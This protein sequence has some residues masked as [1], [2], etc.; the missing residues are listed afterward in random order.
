MMPLF[1]FAPQCCDAINYL[2]A[3]NQC[4]TDGLCYGD[5]RP[6]GD[7]LWFAIPHKL[8]WP[9]ESLITINFILLAI[10]SLLSARAFVRLAA[11]KLVNNQTIITDKPKL[12]SLSAFLPF[13]LSLAAHLFFFWPTIFTALADPP[14][15][16]LLLI[17]GWLLIFAS[18]NKQRWLVGVQFFLSGL[19]L[20]FSVWMRAFYLYPVIFGLAVYFFIWAFSKEKKIQELLLLL[21][22]LPI[23]V[24]YATMNKTY[25]A[26]SYLNAEKTRDVSRMHLNSL[27]V[28]YDTVL[29]GSGYSWMPRRCGVNSGIFDGVQH[30]DYKS[31]ACMI[32]SRLD[33]YLG[34]YNQTTYLQAN[35]NNPDSVRKWQPV[36]LFLNIA[37]LLLA[38]CA[39]IKNRTFWLQQRAG[40][41]FLVTMLSTAAESLLI[42]A[43]QRFAVGWLVF[44]WLM[45]T[46]AA[47]PL[48]Y[49]ER[50]L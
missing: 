31:V 49:R 24:Q 42:I 19:C 9:V 21:I 4:F 50:K 48:V 11:I 36:L 35:I 38:F 47:I 40:V 22:L 8:G 29:P 25:G 41:F 23:G 7:Y 2:D 12:Y 20:G 13:C 28:A 1:E 16:L 15:S 14:A 44:F 30:G 34:T 27:I 32:F 26:Y 17:G 6:I 43:E 18:L 33:F 5:I 10:S 3:G 46:S 45:A 37:A 39:A